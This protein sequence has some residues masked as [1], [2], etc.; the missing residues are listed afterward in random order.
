MKNLFGKTLVVL[1]FIFSLLLFAMSGAVYMT[2][3]NWRAKAEA[4][5][6]K[7]VA[8]TAKLEDSGT[9]LGYRSQY[10]QLEE[11]IEIEEA[12]RDQVVDALASEVNQRKEEYETYC[13]TIKEQE[14]KLAHHSVE[15]L[16][17][18]IF[19][20]KSRIQADDLVVKVQNERN[21]RIRAMHEYINNMNKRED[22]NQQIST[23]QKRARSLTLSQKD[24]DE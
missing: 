13:A 1:I 8:A 19:M 17:F 21:A 10:K 24:S 6:K 2:H 7:V 23:L 18:T 5:E 16:R 20:L 14:D 4:E 22:L 15:M 3:T 9:T 12:L 11:E